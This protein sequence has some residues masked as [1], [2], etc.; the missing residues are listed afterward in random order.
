VKTGVKAGVICKYCSANHNEK[1][2]G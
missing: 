1:M 2:I